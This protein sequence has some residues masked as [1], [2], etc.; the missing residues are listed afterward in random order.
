MMRSHSI[1]FDSHA[2][3][4]ETRQADHLACKNCKQTARNTWKYHGNQEPNKLFIREAQFA[5]VCQ[6]CELQACHK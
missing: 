6:L 5:T 4:M 1:K 3:F 2:A